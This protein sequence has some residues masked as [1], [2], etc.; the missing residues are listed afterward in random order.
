MTKPVYLFLDGVLTMVATYVDT[1][2]DDD[3]KTKARFTQ[4]DWV[5]GMLMDP[6]EGDELWE[7]AL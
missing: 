6:I 5:G 1:V 4:I 2:F 3:C 7:C